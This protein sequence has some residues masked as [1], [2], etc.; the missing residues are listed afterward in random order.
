MYNVCIQI[1]PAVT[2]N[3][4]RSLRVRELWLDVHVT[5]P[6]PTTARFAHTYF[7]QCV[8]KTSGFEH[9][10]ESLLANTEIES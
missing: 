7:K 5:L 3:T 4:A 1:L 10:F 9:W 8:H 6:A 2:Q